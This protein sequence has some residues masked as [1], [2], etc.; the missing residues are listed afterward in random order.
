MDPI[1]DL[2]DPEHKITSASA[3]IQKGMYHLFLLTQRPETDRFTHVLRMYQCLFSL[4]CSMLFLNS[5]FR[6]NEEDLKRGKKILTRFKVDPTKPM[7]EKID[8]TVLLTHSH[9]EKA[10]P[11]PPGHPLCS[12]NMMANALIQRVNDARHTLIYRPMLLAGD[13]W[14]WDDCK[15]FEYFARL[16]GPCEVERIY[17]DFCL[18][19]VETFLGEKERRRRFGYSQAGVLTD[20]DRAEL[21]SFWAGK[22][23]EAIFLVYRDTQGDRPPETILLGYARLLSGDNLSV[24]NTVR[25]FRNA[26]LGLEKVSTLLPEGVG[27]V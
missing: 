21:H 8:P 20:S 1:D 3:L 16:P 12:A 4:S 22:L 14:L 15:L 2:N 6:L 27:D 11:F 5:K 23:L 25:E 9:V 24:V 18:A 17:K 13:P 7:R 19:L 10:P 26:L